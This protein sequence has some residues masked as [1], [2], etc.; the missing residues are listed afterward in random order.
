VGVATNVLANNAGTAV[1]FIGAVVGTVGTNVFI[2]NV[3]LSTGLRVLYYGLTT[4]ALN[5]VYVVNANNVGGPNT[6]PNFTLSRASDL[7]YWW[8]FVKPKVWLATSGTNN[9]AVTF[10]L[11]TDAWEVGSAFQIA[12]GT[13]LTVLSG[14]AIA[15]GASNYTPGLNTSLIYP[16]Y[17]NAVGFNTG[18]YQFLSAAS[19][20]K[21]TYLKNRARRM[22]YWIFKLRE[23]YTPLTSSYQN[24][25]PYPIGSGNTARNIGVSTLNDLPS[26]SRYPSSLNR[27]W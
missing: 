10:A 26:G 17:S 4:S 25:I 19:I 23:N 3:G 14:T 5:G 8:Q 7:T 12:L 16:A 18:E 13:N 2:D 9:K 15:I 1:S 11:Q 27:G 20:S 22:A 21:F 24:A 6:L